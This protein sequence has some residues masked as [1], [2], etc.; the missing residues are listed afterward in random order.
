[1]AQ[2]R[3]FFRV[4]TENQGFGP[5]NENAAR[6]QW[7]ASPMLSRLPDC[8]RQL[9]RPRLGEH[10]GGQCGN[11]VAGAQGA[12]P[13]SIYV[14]GNENL[15]PPQRP[16]GVHPA[17]PFAWPGVSM[18]GFIAQCC[19]MCTSFLEL[20]LRCFSRN[21]FKLRSRLLKCPYAVKASFQDVQ[22]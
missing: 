18:T 14:G 5:Q 9:P 19:V 12:A 11:P 22:F 13:R 16:R 10:Q 15:P 2:G 20:G 8:F 3:A 1:M 4:I 7:A 21:D 17:A 6:P